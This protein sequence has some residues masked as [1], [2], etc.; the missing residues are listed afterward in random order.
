MNLDDFI[1]D[2]NALSESL[3]QPIPITWRVDP[4]DPDRTLNATD[5][6]R[7]WADL[8][9]WVEWLV[10]RYSLDHRTVPPCWFLHGALVDELT[11]L[12][13]AWQVAY[14]PMGSAA[15]PANWMQVFAN[16]RARLTD[17]TARR[18]CRPDD[19]RPDKSAPRPIGPSW[20]AHLASDGSLR[21]DGVIK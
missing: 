14:W 8:R 21:G 5:A 18:G 6:E 2:P 12:W 1:A 17:W 9:D 20:D 4:A 13:G 16:T 19:H 10:E 11:A 15:D 7:L 3:A